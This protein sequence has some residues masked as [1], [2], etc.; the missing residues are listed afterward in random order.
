MSGL[1]KILAIGGADAGP[2][3][4]DVTVTALP[5]TEVNART[6]GRI[7]P[8]LVV[9]PLFGPDFDAIDA[10]TQLERYGYR[11][12]VL[13][14]TPVLPN[15]RI[16]ERELAAVVPGLRVRLTGPAM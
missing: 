15:S 1:R 8:D 9:M 6:I 4:E 7:L 14:R 3:Q 13:V 12:E 10:L 16:V 2:Q 11:G 5:F